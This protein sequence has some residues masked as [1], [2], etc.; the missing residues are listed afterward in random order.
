MVISEVVNGWADLKRALVDG[1]HMPSIVPERDQK[2]NS[3][4]FQ[5]PN[6]KVCCWVSPSSSCSIVTVSLRCQLG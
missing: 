3:P 1:E 6:L 5:V 2:R 4:L